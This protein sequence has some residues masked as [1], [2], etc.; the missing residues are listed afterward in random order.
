MALDY[1]SGLSRYR[2]YLQVVRNQPLIKAGI[3]TSLS[4]V[5]VIVMITMALRPTLVVIAGLLGQI[6]QDKQIIAKLDD[7]IVKIQQASA[8]LNNIS[9]RLPTL[10]EAIPAGP[11]WESW[12]EELANIASQS[13]VQLEAVEVGPAPVA[14]KW[15]T[16]ET[17]STNLPSGIGDLDFTVT[18]SGNYDD[19]KQMVAALENTRRLNVLSNVQF[20]SVKTNTGSTELS[21]Y[22][23][24]VAVYT[25]L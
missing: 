7:K 9:P 24:G 23:K 4:L 13:G 6:K 11:N 18:A 19:L 10:D 12:S 21:V 1:K 5:L 17:G 2:R 15:E 22:V 3:W 14:G 25:Q 16:T 20:N 8:E